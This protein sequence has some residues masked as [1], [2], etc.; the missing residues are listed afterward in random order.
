MLK[1]FL[2]HP[3]HSLL[4]P[5]CTKAKEHVRDAKNP[6]HIS[7]KSLPSSPPWLSG[8]IKRVSPSLR[9]HMWGLM[10]EI[11]EGWCERFRRDD[12]RDDGRDESLETPLNKGFFVS[13]WER[14][15]KLSLHYAAKIGKNAH[16]PSNKRATK[17]P[18]QSFCDFRAFYG[19]TIRDAIVQWSHL[20]LYNNVRAKGWQD[21]TDKGKKTK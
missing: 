19:V 18:E 3:S 13:R 17:R 15:R 14:W 16:P 6:S 1:L 10:W 8:F 20:I 11:S 9:S 21:S 12:G 7:P 5:L 2:P 4:K